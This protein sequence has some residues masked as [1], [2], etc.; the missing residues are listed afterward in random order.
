MSYGSG[1]PRSACG[2]TLHPEL[3]YLD[4]RTCRRHLGCAGLWEALRLKLGLQSASHTPS[5]PGIDRSVTITSG[6][7]SQRTH[8]GAPAV[9]HSIT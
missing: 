9:H 3:S 1:I 7:T 4:G 5:S 6:R 2:E 8:Q